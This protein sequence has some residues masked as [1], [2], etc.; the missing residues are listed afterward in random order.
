MENVVFP[1]DNVGNFMNSHFISIH[2]QMD[3][4][5]NDDENTKNWYSDAHE[6]QKEYKVTAFPTYLFFSPDGEIVHRFIGA[7]T[8]SLFLKIANNALNPEKQYYS[9]FGNYKRGKKDYPRLNSLAAKMKSIGEDTLAKVIATDYLHNYLSKLSGKDLLQKKYFDFIASFPEILSSR[10]KIVKLLYKESEKIDQIV[11]QKFFANDI[12]SMVMTKEIIDRRLKS[13]VGVAIK[14]E[15]WKSMAKEIRKSYGKY[16]ADSIITNAQ[17]NWYRDKKPRAQL[18]KYLV[19]KYDTYGVGIDTAG[20]GFAFVNN[21]IYNLFFKHCDNRDTLNKAIRWMEII[22]E[23][24][25]DNWPGIDTYANLLHKVGRT[26][27]AIQWQE[28]AVRLEMEAAKRENRNP[29]PEFQETLE[30]MRKGIP[31]W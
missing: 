8:D 12:I 23:R 22:N 11:N 27:E 2:V 21:D 1:L 17:I 15:E 16:D 9:L 25:P 28:K 14:E 5:I 30:K 29:N 7:L 18:M 13:A 24:H 3:T 31:T 10:D 4:A 26:E 20:V 19:K 6:L